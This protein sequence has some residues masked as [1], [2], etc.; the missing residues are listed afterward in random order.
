MR[1]DQFLARVIPPGNFAA[2]NWKRP[3][4]DGMPGRFFPPTARGEAVGLMH[5]LAARGN[6]TYFALASFNLAESD[7][8]D[9]QGRPKFKGER[10]H[11]NVQALR[12]FW[13]DADVKRDGDGKTK[14][15]FT[16]RL[17]AEQWL[18][19]FLTAT[20]LPP[21]NL[22]V[23]SGY[24]FHWYWVLEDPMTWV[25]WQPYADALRGALIAHGFKCEA[26]ISSDAARILRPPGTSNMKAVPQGGQRVPVEVMSD[27]TRGDYPNE[28]VLNRLKPYLGSPPPATTVG[29][30]A[31]M[32]AGS[33]PAAVFQA[34]HANMTAAAQAN[35]P[36]ASRP[37]QFSRIATQ[38][39]QVKQSLAAGGAGDHYQLWYL[40]FLSLA[41]HCEDGAQFVHP[42]SQ[43]DPRY[44]PQNV[45]N[46]VARIATEK[47]KKDNGPPLCTSF[48]S[49]RPGVCQGCL[50]NGKVA[51][52]WNL[53]VD[54]TP[55][56]NATTVVLSQAAGTAAST[57]T[58]GESIR[59][60]PHF[61]TEAEAELHLNV[62]IFKVT[63]WGNSPSFGMFNRDGSIS[64]LKP[65]AL[66]VYLAGHFVGV[67]DGRGGTKFIPAAVWWTQSPTKLVFDAVRYDPEGMYTLPS[68]IVLN[69][70]RGFAVQPVKGSWRRMR[71]HIWRVIC[72]RNRSTFKYLIRF[73][74]H[75]VQHPGTN[76]E[77]MVVIRS[78][79][80][81]VG[82][83]SLGQWLIRMFGPHA[84]E[85]ADI[86][87]VFGQFNESLANISFALLEE[88]I[89]PGNKKSAEMSRAVVT[90]K[91]MQIN[92]KG[93][94]AYEIPH[95]IHFMMTTNGQWAIPAGAEARRY[96]MLDVRE[97]VP[98]RSYFNALW[99]EADGGGVAAMLHDLLAANIQGFNPRMVPATAA[100]VEQQR[101]SADDITQWVTDWILCGE[102]SLPAPAGGLSISVQGGG[103][104]QILANGVLYQSYLAWVAAQGVRRPKTSREFGRALGELGLKRGAGNN[105]PKWAVPDRATL[106]AAANRRAGIRQVS[107]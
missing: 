14:S 10:K 87:Q 107:K 51:T 72:G 41:H 104:S 21:P 69:T 43:G 70:W 62:R 96:L 58:R 56:S 91:S 73:L 98:P 52:P 53:G 76:P 20:S 103:F 13:I 89:F 82:K 9:A 64:P 68:E 50:L 92:P 106:L 66:T 18:D 85:F 55:S 94:P 4:Q 28:L 42:I 15:I 80:E 38:C 78:T 101:R 36:V 5:W 105:P 84:R 46:H 90:A 74:A 67:P 16:T 48:D 23:N 2:F 54:D 22:W 44:N 11:E 81:G 29:T 60:M 19:Q 17:E 61:M 75:L 30:P 65:E 27:H 97:D 37:R 77:V 45:D 86:E 8:A 3:G 39:E 31:A 1:T 33:G 95:G 24:G 88:V 99:A 79:R 83:S 57:P 40:G 49:W 25:D 47:A 34:P 63:N 35:L 7:G 71:R 26:G 6:D 100:L 59:N 93:R 32:L 102:L 12:S